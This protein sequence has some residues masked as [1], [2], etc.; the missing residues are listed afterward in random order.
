[1]F[2]IMLY[3]LA[4]RARPERE[5]VTYDFSG[6]TFPLAEDNDLNRQIAVELLDG[7]GASLETVVNGEE[8][9][10][11]FRESEPGHY[12]LV[13]MDIQIPVMNDYDAAR[14]IRAL[15]RSDARTV[16]IIAMTADA[17][18]EDIRSA[19]AAGMNGHIAKPLDVQTMALKLNEYLEEVVQRHEPESLYLHF[20]RKKTIDFF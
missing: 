6:K 15:S 7:L 12:A 2:C 11:R 9:I 8:A 4:G 19:E 18:V 14:A 13:L 10:R 16:P 1:M 5:A 17:F 20:Q 3:C